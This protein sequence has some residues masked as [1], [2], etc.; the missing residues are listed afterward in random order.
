MRKPWTGWKDPVD[1]EWLM[2]EKVK[3]TG[4]ALTIRIITTGNDEGKTE[5]E[6]PNIISAF[7]QFTSPTYNKFKP[8][9][10]KSL[11]LLMRIIFSENSPG[12]KSPMSQ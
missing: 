12:G 3:K 6:L 7:S 1:E 5:A 2:K 10:R 4:Y 9:K 8:V 11:S